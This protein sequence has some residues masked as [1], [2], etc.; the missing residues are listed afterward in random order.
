MT[1]YSNAFSNSGLKKLTIPDCYP[2]YIQGYAFDGSQ[3]TEVIS[4]IEWPEDLHSDAFNGIPENA[5]LKV[6]YGQ[7]YE[8]EYRTGWDH[9]YGHIEEMP[10]IP[11]GI[12][13][14]TCEPVDSS[15]VYDLQGRRISDNPSSLK[16]GIYII[17]G[18]KVMVK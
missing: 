16:R 18:K 9:F 4:Y 2:F 1:I 15:T 10:Y 14:S 5:T 17:G 3:L 8:Y 12:D 7:Q 6:P 11:T 13:S